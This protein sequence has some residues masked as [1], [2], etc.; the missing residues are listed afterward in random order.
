VRVAVVSDDRLFADALVHMLASGDAT[1]V[2]D[3]AREADVALLDS[4]I[5]RAFACCS[6]LANEHEPSVIFV[7][8]PEDDDWAYAALESGARGV[9]P[10][11]ASGE[12]LMMAVRGVHAGLIW[13]RR[14]VL[15]ARIDH[16]TGVTI[17]RRSA[18]LLLERELSARER[19]V[20]RFAAAGLG[21]KE[22]AAR[23]RISEATVKVH[24]TH[25]FQK[26]GV[27]GRAELAA[28]YHRV[29]L[30]AASTT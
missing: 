27:R 21:N 8:A 15:A 14:R 6:E 17:Q 30:P 29:M 23:L 1:V 5:E 3:D 16:L 24:L 7:G 2:I 4:R 12:D 19:E 22:V 18:E 20:F 9:L 10:K 26:L 11:S 13:A 25:I 28:A